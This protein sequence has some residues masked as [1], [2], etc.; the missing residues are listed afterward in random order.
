[1]ISKKNI[2]IYAKL[3]KITKL[4]FYR[5]CQY[6]SQSEAQAVGGYRL[7]EVRGETLTHTVAAL[8]NMADCMEHESANTIRVCCLCDGEPLPEC[9]LAELSESLKGGVLK[10]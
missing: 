8:V 10:L 2:K 6:A 7:L 9:S 4:G 3:R 1:M 5:S